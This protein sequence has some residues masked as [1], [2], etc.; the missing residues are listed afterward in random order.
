MSKRCI[1]FMFISTQRPTSRTQH[2]PG[3]VCLHPGSVH[4]QETGTGAGMHVQSLYNLAV[5]QRFSCS[6][7]LCFLWLS[8]KYHNSKSKIFLEEVTNKIE[9]VLS[10]FIFL[11]C[12]ISIILDFFKCTFAQADILLSRP[13]QSSMGTHLFYLYLV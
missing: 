3:P 5:L 9:L 4:M 13:M 2:R 6:A 11:F 7:F 1:I 8:V 10:A 12:I